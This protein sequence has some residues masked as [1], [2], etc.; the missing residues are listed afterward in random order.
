MALEL[1]PP[2]LFRDPLSDDDI[3]EILFRLIEEKEAMGELE[4]SV[5]GFTL[6]NEQ[7]E[8]V[9]VYLTNAIAALRRK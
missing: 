1:R 3:E 4:A 2:T 7:A 8:A 9:R 5:G 6:F